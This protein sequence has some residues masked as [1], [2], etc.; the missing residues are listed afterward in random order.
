VTVAAK[1]PVEPVNGGVVRFIP[2]PAANGASALLS[3]SSVVITGGRAGVT[4]APDNADGSYQVVASINA[5]S[6]SFNLTNVGPVYASLVVNTTSDALAPGAGLLSLREA[7]GFANNDRSG[8]TAITFDPAVFNTAKTIT[9]TGSQLELSNTSENETIT[10]PA[11]GVTVN[12]GR[13]SRVFQVDGLVTA[14]LSGLTITGGKA[15]GIGDFAA[16]NGGGV[17]NYGTL[18]LTNC[19]V[20]GNSV[21]Y[22]VGGVGV[23][24]GVANFGAATLTNCTVSGNSANHGFFFNG[25]D[26]GG[27]YNNG[28]AM[29][30]NCTV[31]GNSALRGGGVQNYGTLALTNCTVSGNSATFK[32][33]G[34]GGGVVNRDTA[35]LTNCTVS[36]NS[37]PGVGGVLNYGTLA[38]TNCTV[39]GN[40]AH[41]NGDGGLFNDGTA[42]LT[43][44]TISGNSADRTGGVSNFTPFGNAPSSP[45]SK[46]IV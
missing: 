33:G 4:A 44:C 6:A 37:A 32:Y 15:A 29:L 35:M 8:N 9:L 25:G 19:T 17:Q 3:A 41:I 26:G 11:A 23:G 36:G 30:T 40:S 20:S 45:G 31:S 10:G 42:T 43:N 18:T 46:A 27:V 1:N 16:G 13:L 34:G 7:I 38:L 5:G 28:A 2:H 14:S 22:G 12:G 39:S 24:G 21:G